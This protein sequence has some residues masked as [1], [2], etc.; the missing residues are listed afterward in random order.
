MKNAIATILLIIV[1]FGMFSCGNEILPIVPPVNTTDTLLN[2]ISV[3]LSTS[4][5][6]I[7]HAASGFLYGF[8]ATLPTA[9][10]FEALTPKLV[11]YH[12]MMDYPDLYGWH[13]EWQLNASERGNTSLKCD[14][15]MNRLKKMGVRQQIIAGSEYTN[16]GYQNSVGWPGDPLNNGID[17]NVLF[18]QVLKE[19]VQYVLSKGFKNI[20]WDVWNEPDASDFWPSNRFPDQYLAT[21][22]FGYQTIKKY[23]PNAIIVGPSYAAF[24]PWLAGKTEGQTMREFLN[25]AKQ[26]SCMPDRL[27]WHELNGADSHRKILKH[28]TDIRNYMQNDLKMVPLPIDIPEIIVPEH[29]YHPGIYVWHF[30]ELEKAKVEGACHAVWEEDPNMWHPDFPV[31]AINLSRGLWAGHLCHILTRADQT[32]AFSPRATWYTYKKY[33]EMKGERVAVTAKTEVPVNG[34]VAFDSKNKK[35]RGL[36]G[37]DSNTKC[38]ANIV[39]SNTLLTGEK[40]SLKFSISRI[41]DSGTQYVSTIITE[42]KEFLINASQVVISLNFEPYEAIYIEQVK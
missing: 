13:W 3:D 21:W 32:P 35:V 37:N 27:V 10:L 17:P 34:I 30:A 15:M 18:E 7:T 8:S 14:A 39:M 11:R 42:Q 24:E 16:R 41:P 12:A 5:D 20:E 6:T 25:F 36:F 22:K 26:N 38:K 4:S 29:L 31:G 28:V 19:Q 33:T 23:D 9:D 1:G 40:T 2:K